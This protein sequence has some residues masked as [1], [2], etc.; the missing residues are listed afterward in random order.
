VIAAAITHK[1]KT[2]ERKGREVVARGNK[3]GERE[4]GRKKCS[5]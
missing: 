2:R 3:K 5:E 4:S 1:D